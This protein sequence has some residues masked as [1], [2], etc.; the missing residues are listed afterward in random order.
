VLEAARLAGRDG[1]DDLSMTFCFQGAPGTGKTTVARRMGMLFEAIGALPSAEVVQC[2][3]S[4]LVTGYVGQ[5]AKKTRDV[6]E[7]ARG[8]VLFIDEAYRL[9][10]PTGR[11]YMQEAV[12]EIVT[13]LTEETYKGKMVVIFAGYSGQMEELL[14]KVNPGL[15]SRVADVIDFPNFDATAAAEIA[16]SM[17][18]QKRLRLA[19]SLP[20]EVVASDYAQ[21]LVHAPQ[22]AAA[23]PLVAPVRFGS[24]DDDSSRRASCPR[25]AGSKPVRSRTSRV[26]G[27]YDGDDVRWSCTTTQ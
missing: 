9:Y 22:V 17:L 16:E 25:A 8:A 4:D 11:S 19:P 7:S 2:S 14:D 15:K 27:T 5:A 12:D 3:A 13:L 26:S 20:R 1:M 21:R 18:A 10:D 23:G 6:F 24:G